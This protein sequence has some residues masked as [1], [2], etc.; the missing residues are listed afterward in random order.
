VETQFHIQETMPMSSEAEASRK[1]EKKRKG[2]KEKLGKKFA[3]GKGR[4]IKMLPI[5][6]TLQAS[7][8]GKHQV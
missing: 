4:A 7:L 2:K 5:D 6:P 3:W 8:K 1:K